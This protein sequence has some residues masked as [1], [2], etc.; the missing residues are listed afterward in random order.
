MAAATI[1]SKGQVTIPREV[2][3]KFG[4]H[5]GDRIDFRIEA[6][7]TLR[8]VPET[9]RADDVFG[10]LAERGRKGK[11]TVEAMDRQLRAAFRKKDK[12]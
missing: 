1:T 10:L 8:V 6:D 5:A 4:L 3:A 2:R 11:V 12:A 7:G 9:V